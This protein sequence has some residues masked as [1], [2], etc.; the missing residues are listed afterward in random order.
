MAYGAYDLDGDV[1]SP[2]GEMSSYGGVYQNGIA[3]KYMTAKTD[4]PFIQFRILPPFHPEGV[5]VREGRVVIVDPRTWTHFRDPATEKLNPFGRVVYAS[6]CVGHGK[7]GASGSRKDIL[8]PRSFRH[9]GQPYCPVSVLCDTIERYPDWQYLTSDMA[10]EDGRLIDRAAINRPSKMFA[11]NIVDLAEPQKGVQLGV[12]TASGCTSL[13][14]ATSGLVFQRSNIADEAFLAQS[15]M[16]RWATGDLTAPEHGPVLRMSKEQGRGKFGKYVITMA[17]GPGG[18][19]LRYPIGDE[20]LIRRY[21]LLDEDALLI[22]LSEEAIVAKL[23]QVLNGV[24]PTGRHEYELLK[25]AFG[26]MFRIPDPPRQGASP[27]FTPP[28]PPQAPA[29]GG[30][31][32]AYQQPRVATDALAGIPGAERPV[33]SIRPPAPIRPPAMESPV[34]GMAVPAHPAAPPVGVPG[35]Q[36][37]APGDPAPDWDRNNFLNQMKAA[38]TNPPAPGRMPETPRGPAIV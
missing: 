3:V 25:I 33:G 30:Y 4:V 14:G 11:A 34:V 2:S 38:G 18:K 32:G 20:L 10:S 36:A 24:S 12:F 27:G 6:S 5:E 13:I 28:Q 31:P 37:P 16:A 15:P 29:Q 19:I 23:V 9:E 26:E 1:H 35:A 8:S 22:R 21:N 17:E 7:V